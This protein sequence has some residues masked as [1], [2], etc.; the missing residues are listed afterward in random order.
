MSVSRTLIQLAAA[1]ALGALLTA[2][3]MAAGPSIGKLGVGGTGCPAGTVSAAVGSNTLSLKYS[4]YIASAGGARSFDRKACGV[5]I[6]FQVPAGL[7]VAIVGVQYRGL[8]KL[9]SGATS[10]L[11]TELFFAG[12]KGPVVTR[13]F[14][15]P[16]TGKFDLTTVSGTPIW[17][18]CG[19]SLNLR[20]QSSLK[21]TT[22]GGKS[23]STSIRTQDVAAGLVYQL[24]FKSC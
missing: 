16:V 8:N 24:K 14:K 6:P 23:A 3:A 9:P 11:S 19:A 13:T 20:I 10:V 5:A 4:K 18:A 1:L 17:S 15:G 7:S 21:V 12:G 2:P 22:S